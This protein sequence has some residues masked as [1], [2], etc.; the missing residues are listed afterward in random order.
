MRVRVSIALFFLAI[1]GSSFANDKKETVKLVSF[2]II[3]DGFDMGF[4]EISREKKFSLIKVR[5]GE[6]M[7]VASSMFVM[8]GMYKI[9]QQRKCKIM[10]VSKEWE[11]KDE[12]WCYKVYFFNRA[13]IPLKRLLG[14]DYSD[15]AQ[16]TFD[17]S[18]YT[19]A[20]EFDLFFKND[21]Q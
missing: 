7:S 16:E 2:E 3:E 9:A 19:K 10:F 15:E 8:R 20:S 17:E 12:N 5:H 1:C 13:R 4:D 21:F 6:G 18:G 14:D 11:D